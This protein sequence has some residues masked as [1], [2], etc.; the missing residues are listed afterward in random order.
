[1]TKIK[2]LAYI[3]CCLILLGG[4]STVK[5]KLITEKNKDTILEEIKDTRDLT[6]E[7]VRILMG[8]IFRVGMSNAFGKGKED[9]FPVGK[10]IG[11]VIADERK[12]AAEAAK[13]EEEEKVRREKAAA[14]DEALRQNMRNSLSVTVYE[15]G[16]RDSDW[17]NGIYK[18]VITLKVAYENHSNKD[19]RG[20][21]GT[22]VFNDLFG[23]L[24][25]K[26]NLQEDEI[27]PAGKAKKV[28]LTIDYNQ[29]L[30]TDTRLKTTELK[31][32][33]ITWEPDTILF[34]DGTNISV[35]SSE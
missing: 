26:S 2:E 27:L 33:N 35:H 17:Q 16:F 14:E 15:K 1:M 10:T 21:K 23:K 5:D 11:E 19:I 34:T 22:V 18:D 20:F 29:F 9:S 24:I 12:S 6:V 7:E 28:A 32:M 30:D 8:R 13:K 3:A 25:A 4:C 31:N